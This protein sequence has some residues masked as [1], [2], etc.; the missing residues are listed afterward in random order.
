ME[1][2]GNEI[3]ISGPAAHWGQDIHR[4]AESQSWPFFVIYRGT[5]TQRINRGRR[6]RGISEQGDLFLGNALSKPTVFNNKLP[7]ETLSRPDQL[8]RFCIQHRMKSSWCLREGRI[9][10]IIQSEPRSSPSNDLFLCLLS[11]FH[12]TREGGMWSVW[13]DMWSGFGK[14]EQMF[15]H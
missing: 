2:K 9:L 4:A 5:G 11:E 6:G 7:G 3:N 13:S 14:G 15:H 12:F 1:W 8:V 10:T